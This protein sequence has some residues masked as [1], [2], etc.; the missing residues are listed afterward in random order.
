[1]N[2][3]NIK[4]IDLFGGTIKLMNSGITTWREGIWVKKSYGFSEMSLKVF[5][6]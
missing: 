6:F 5:F 4:V 1:M 2:G 3:C